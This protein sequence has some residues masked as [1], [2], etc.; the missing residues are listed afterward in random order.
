MTWG[1]VDQPSAGHPSTKLG[2][3]GEILPL[4]YPRLDLDTGVQAV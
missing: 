4:G 1:H 2:L 3:K